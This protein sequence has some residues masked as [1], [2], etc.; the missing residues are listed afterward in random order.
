LTYP[1]FTTPTVL[2]EKLIERYN[3]PPPPGLTSEQMEEYESDILVVRLRY[4]FGVGLSKRM[5]N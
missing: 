3:Q 5:Y 4:D 2:L 1:S